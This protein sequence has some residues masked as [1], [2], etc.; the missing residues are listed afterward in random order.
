M[1]ICIHSLLELSINLVDRVVHHSTCT[2]LVLN[3]NKYFKVLSRLNIFTCSV[4][5]EDVHVITRQVS[6]SE[7]DP[8]LLAPTITER[9]VPPSK[10]LFISR[11]SRFKPSHLEEQ[12]PTSTMSALLICNCSKKGIVLTDQGAKKISLP[13]YPLGEL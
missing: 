9:P 8:A 2:S 12:S 3:S 5:K 7:N 10:E 11:K 1:K 6:L 4:N 13:A